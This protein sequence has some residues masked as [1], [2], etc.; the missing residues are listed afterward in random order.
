MVFWAES[1]LDSCPMTNFIVTDF[2]NL[3]YVHHSKPPFK[4]LQDMK[5]YHLDHHY[6]NYNLGY[7]VTSKFWDN[8]F[9]TALY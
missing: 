8:I 6:K 2:S 7:G 3:D 1:C 4:H 5:S 9:S